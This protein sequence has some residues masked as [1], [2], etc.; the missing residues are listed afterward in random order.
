M[1]TLFLIGAL[2]AVMVAQN[3]VPETP[4]LVKYYMGFLKK[5][6]GW[7]ASATPESAELQKQHLA[8]LRRMHEMGKLVVAGPFGDNGEI[9]GILVFR[10]KDSLDEMKKLAEEDPAVKAG[11]MV[12][13]LHPWYVQDG[14]LP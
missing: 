12:V 5:G 14:V 11:R 1:R 13:E 3:P 10:G 4:K 7:N 6:P 9:R 8:H 2:A